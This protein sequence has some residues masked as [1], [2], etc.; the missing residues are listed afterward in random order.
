MTNASDGARIKAWAGPSV[1]AGIVKNI[2]FIGFFETNVGNPIVIDQVW[3]SLN[4]RYFSLIPTP[5]VTSHLPP[6][7]PHTLRT[8]TSKMFAS[9]TSLE[10]GPRLR[11]RR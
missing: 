10:Q 7:V 8:R 3:P 4:R 6:T 5:S 2:T 1:G 9:S 11:S